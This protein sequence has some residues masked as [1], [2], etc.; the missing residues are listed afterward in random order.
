MHRVTRPISDGE[1]G[2]DG[3]LHVLDGQ[4]DFAERQ[5]GQS[6]GAVRRAEARHREAGHDRQVGVRLEELVGLPGRLRVPE[7]VGGVAG[8]EHRRRPDARRR[9]RGEPFGAHRGECGPGGRVITG[10]GGEG[11]DRG[12]EAGARLGHSRRRHEVGEHR[13]H[14]LAPPLEPTDRHQL[15][16]V[17]S[18]RV[19][20]TDVDPE[21]IT[22]VGELLGLGE[23]PLTHREHHVQGGDEITQ[24]VA[25]VRDEVLAEL[26]E[27]ADGPAVAGEEEVDR[28]PGEAHQSVDG[29][30]GRRRDGDQLV[31]EPEPPLGVLR[32]EQAVV[33]QRQGLGELD[34]IRPFPRLLQLGEDRSGLAGHVRLLGGEP[35]AQPPRQ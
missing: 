24:P 18:E 15:G 34:R 32:T 5:R 19:G 12:D 26:T 22:P 3:R 29:A 8:A 6:E 1:V 27:R 33:R 30:A 7:D 9:H 17:P 13:E 14:V 10:G 2:D 31:G 4:I 11:G 28:A 25:T 35:D 16:A 23:P 21:L 20:V